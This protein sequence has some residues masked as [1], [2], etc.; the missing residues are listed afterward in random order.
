VLLPGLAPY[1]FGLVLAG[2][3]APWFATVGTGRWPLLGL[4]F[5]CGLLYSALTGAFL[6]WALDWGEREYLHRQLRHTLGG[7]LGKLSGRAIG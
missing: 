2:L 4:L 1:G 6:Y 3:T 5:I 7:W